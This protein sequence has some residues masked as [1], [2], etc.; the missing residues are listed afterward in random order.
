MPVE[1][2]SSASLDMT[3]RP[4]SGPF[5]RSVNVS[6]AGSFAGGLMRVTELSASSLT[7]N[8]RV[9]LAVGRSGPITLVIAD[10]ARRVL[11]VRVVRSRFIQLDGQVGYVSTFDIAP[12]STEAAAQLVSELTTAARNQ[13]D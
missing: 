1:S 4:E 3:S 2:A 9:R 13:V 10:N 5:G 8:H 11:S 6:T 12:D 7:A